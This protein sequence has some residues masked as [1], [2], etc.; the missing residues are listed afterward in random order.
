VLWRERSQPE[1]QAQVPGVVEAVDVSGFARATGPQPLSFPADYGPHP[2]FQTEWWYYTGNLA[3]GAQADDTD[4]VV[5]D[6]L[7][8]ITETLRG[9]VDR[10]ALLFGLGT[11]PGD[12][13]AGVLQWRLRFAPC[14]L[15]PQ[16]RRACLRTRRWSRWVWSASVLLFV[17]G[18]FF[19][20]VAPWL[21]S[22]G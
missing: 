9:Q 18:A 7:A 6:H 11:Q 22:A 16:L 13:R 10:Q 19:A 14:P 21:M 4:D 3:G 17:V 2:D 8:W 12:I 20:F 15:D 1:V 5:D